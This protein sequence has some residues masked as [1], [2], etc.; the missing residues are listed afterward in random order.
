MALRATGS[1]GLR[2]MKLYA[3]YYEEVRRLEEMENYVNLRT[4]I[5]FQ[6]LT[7]VYTIKTFLSFQATV[8]MLK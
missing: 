8:P 4:R 2:E 5:L 6:K 1:P 3:V 7:V